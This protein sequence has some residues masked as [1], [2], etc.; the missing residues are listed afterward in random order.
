MFG[1][2]QPMYYIYNQQK[3][4]W[5][6]DLGN[7]SWSRNSL[8]F[9]SSSLLPAC[10]FIL[11]PHGII[12]WFLFTT[13]IYCLGDAVTTIPQAMKPQT[14]K[15]TQ[16]LF[17]T[18]HSPELSPSPENLTYSPTPHSAGLGAPHQS[19]PSIFLFL[20]SML[21]YNYHWVCQSLPLD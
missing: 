17:I 16:L 4:N 11:S 21:Y 2:H 6:H 14:Q 3:N 5:H 10:Q 13:C 20:H 8:A 19:N 18:P 7:P 9:Q 1:Y 15:H 12:C